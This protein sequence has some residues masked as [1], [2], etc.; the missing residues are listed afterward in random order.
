MAN[1]VHANTKVRGSNPVTLK[2]G[3]IRAGSLVTCDPTQ[4]SCSK[5]K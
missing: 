2:C 4:I 3:A 1:E 5:C